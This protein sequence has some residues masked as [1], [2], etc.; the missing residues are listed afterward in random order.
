MLALIRSLTTEG[1]AVVLISSDLSEVLRLSHRVLLLREGR[2]IGIMPAEGASL[3]H[4]M[5][6]LTGVT[7]P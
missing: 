5:A 4:V 6:E 3:E 2:V 1:M 7:S